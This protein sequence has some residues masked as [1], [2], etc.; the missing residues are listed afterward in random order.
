MKVHI[1]SFAVTTRSPD[2]N[3]Q[4][5]YFDYVSE[6]SMN[7]QYVISVW[8]QFRKDFEL[9]RFTKGIFVWSDNGINKR[10]SLYKLSELFKDNKLRI[11]LHYF[12]PSHGHSLADSHFGNI[13]RILR[14]RL[15]GSLLTS[16]K[17]LIK[18]TAQKGKTYI[19]YIR[20]D[21]TLMP[22]IEGFKRGIRKYREIEIL[23]EG[24]FKA[25]KLSCIGSRIEETLNIKP[26][27]NRGRPKKNK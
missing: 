24:K 4:R 10:T 16:V 13:K 22:P 19:K 6:H 2:G 12:I 21:D 8:K 9:K 17:Q 27:R 5:R 25:R 11:Q 3:L 20:V 26:H 15:I 7:A 14:R 23:A 1:F 18:L